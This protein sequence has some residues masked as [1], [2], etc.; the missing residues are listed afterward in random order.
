VDDV[1]VSISKHRCEQYA[2]GTTALQENIAAPGAD[3]VF[4]VALTNGLLAVVAVAVPGHAA[5]KTACKLP[6]ASKLL[7]DLEVTFGKDAAGVTEVPT[8]ENAQDLVGI[9]LVD[10]GYERTVR[11]EVDLLADALART[12][13][14]RHGRGPTGLL[15]S[16]DVEALAVL[17]EHPA[18]SVLAD[19]RREQYWDRGS[20]ADT[21]E[22]DRALGVLKLL[23]DA[24]I[25]ARVMSVASAH[26]LPVEEHELQFCPV[27]GNQ[28]L[29]SGSTDSWGYGIVAATCPVCSFE[30][31]EHGAE[32]LNL[33]QEWIS[34]WAD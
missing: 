1:L 23:T 14:A 27:C 17:D 28:T 3:G 33:D 20:A 7:D 19:Y 11:V 8:G 15:T 29:V 21:A 6:P 31:S 13:A 30:Q 26:G 12:Q 18:L 10:L 5:A 32:L 2:T 4:D 24:D 34:R 9:G 25:A 16:S 22:F